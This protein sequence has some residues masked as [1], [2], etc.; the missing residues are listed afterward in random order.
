MFENTGVSTS[1]S[2][3][4]PGEEASAERI[5]DVCSRVVRSCQQIDDKKQRLY[6]AVLMAV[7]GKHTIKDA[8]TTHALPGMLTPLTFADDSI[9][10]AQ[11]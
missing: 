9:D 8:C 1:R 7:S 11:K 4:K 10:S 5:A 6:D 3:A 2:Y